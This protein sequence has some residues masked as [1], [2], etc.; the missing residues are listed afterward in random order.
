MTRSINRR[1]YAAGLATALTAGLLV[2]GPASGSAAPTAA[3]P[4]AATKTGAATG[5]DQVTAPV[6]VIN[7]QPCRGATKYD[8]AVVKAP[9]DYDNPNGPSVQLDLARFKARNQQAKLGTIFVN[10]GGPG[11]SSTSF[12]PAMAMFFEK[13]WPSLVSS[14]SICLSRVRVS[15]DLSTPARR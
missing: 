9:L 11:G 5:A 6:P 15:G 1:L 10:P 12:V 13:S 7:W 2:A 4:T 3:A 14:S 8:C